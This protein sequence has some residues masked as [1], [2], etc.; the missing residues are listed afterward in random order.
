MLLFT[1]FACYTTADYWEDV[2]EAHCSCSEPSQ[3]ELC[4]EEQLAVYDE[5][6]MSDACGADDAP[7]GWMEVNSWASDYTADC[8]LADSEP[9][10]VEEEYWA[11]CLP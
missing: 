11:E 4:V 9:P 5:S 6:G 3:I 2:A 1:L 10:Y 8:D 7:V